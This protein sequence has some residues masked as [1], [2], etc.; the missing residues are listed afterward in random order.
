MSAV[1]LTALIRAY[2]LRDVKRYGGSMKKLLLLCCAVAVLTPAIYSQVATTG[3][4]VA[5]MNVSTVV[6]LNMLTSAEITDKISNGWTSRLSRTG[7]PEIRGPH[8]VIGVHSILATHRAIEAAKRLGKTIV[9]PTLPFAVAATGG[10][11]AG[12]W[13]TFEDSGTI[14]PNPGAIQVT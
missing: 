5:G 3:Q 13:K 6:E 7:G 4:G 2:V 10:Y 12:S 9:A 8:A 1:H 14:A 11:N